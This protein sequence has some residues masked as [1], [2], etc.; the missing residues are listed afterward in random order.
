MSEHL[1]TDEQSKADLLQKI[2]K[3]EAALGTSETKALISAY[4]LP[5]S[6]AE[7]LSLL[8]NQP[9]VTVEVIENHLKVSKDLKVAVFRLRRELAPYGIE[10]MSRRYTGYWLEEETKERIRAAVTEKVSAQ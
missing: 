4:R 2:A 9:F 8:L 1:S 3:L 10:I 7:L 5:A 6:L